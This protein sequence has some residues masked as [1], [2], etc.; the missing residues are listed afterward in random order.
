[1]IGNPADRTVMPILVDE[2][3]QEVADQAFEVA[4]LRRNGVPLSRERVSAEMLLELEVTGD[5]MRFV[6]AKGRIAWK[7]T[8]QLRDYLMDLQRDAEADLEEF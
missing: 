2:I 4:R 6:D 1:M 8:P 3:L 7:A 5:A